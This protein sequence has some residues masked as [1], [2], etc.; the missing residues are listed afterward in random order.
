[1]RTA[2]TAFGTQSRKSLPFT[3]AGRTF[4]SKPL[5]VGEELTLSDIGDRYDLEALDGEHVAPFIREQC[6]LVADLLNHRLQGEASERITPEWVMRHVNAGTLEALL[7]F[8]RTGERPKRSLD[9]VAWF[10]EPITVQDRAFR[11]TPVNFEEQL[12]AGEIKADG[13]NREI[14]QSSMHYLATLLTHRAEDSQAVTADW[15]TENLGVNDMQELLNLLQ[16]GPQE[17]ED[18]NAEVEPLRLVEADGSN[19]SGA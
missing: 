11:A 14:V 1:M 17:D 7:G 5:T 15:L 8:L 10:D 16:N 9:I 19:T 2:K 3:L 18:P 6:G 4:F 13:S 12:Q